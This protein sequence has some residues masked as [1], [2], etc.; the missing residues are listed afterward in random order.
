MD[1]RQIMQLAMRFR[2]AKPATDE[3]ELALAAWQRCVCAFDKQGLIH[4][5]D[6][7]AFH[8]VADSDGL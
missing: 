6:R 7:K 8:L 2:E 1:T 3:G 4:P 5:D